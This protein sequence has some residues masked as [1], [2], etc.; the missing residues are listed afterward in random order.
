[1]SV[2][3]ANAPEGG[4]PVEK[5]VFRTLLVDQLRRVNSELRA[6]L[7]FFALAGLLSVAAGAHAAVLSL[8]SLPTILSACVCGQEK[9]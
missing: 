6:L 7:L 9:G 8:Y 3:P 5:S 4:A 1:V 2:E